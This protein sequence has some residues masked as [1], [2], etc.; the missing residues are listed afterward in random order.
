MFI[1]I[2]PSHNEYF[3]NMTHVLLVERVVNQKKVTLKITHDHPQIIKKELTH[4]HN[5]HKMT[6]SLKKKKG[7]FVI[8]QTI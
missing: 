1:S 3:H 5:W 4:N 2:S 6:H 7:T 8:H